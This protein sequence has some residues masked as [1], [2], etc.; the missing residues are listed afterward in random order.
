MAPIATPQALQGKFLN[1][2]YQ[3]RPVAD[4]IAVIYIDDYSLADETL[5]RW[6]DWSRTYYATAIENLNEAGAAVIGI[7][8]LFNRESKGLS[9]KDLLQTLTG[10]QTTGSIEVDPSQ[11]FMDLLPYL[12][13]SHPDDIILAEAIEEAGNVVLAKVPYIDPETGEFLGDGGSIDIIS[14]VSAGEGYTYGEMSQSDTILQL[15]AEESFD[16][17]ISEFFTGQ[18]V[19]IPT[20][21]RGNMYVNYSGATGSYKYFSFYDIY[22]NNF[23][24]EDVEGKILLIGVGSATLQDRYTTPLGDSTMPGVEIHANAIQTILENAFLEDA[25]FGQQAI[26]ITLT[27]VIAT[28]L[29]M[30]LPFWI[31]LISLLILGIIN[32]FA[33]KA[34]FNS[35]LILNIIYPYITLLVLYITSVIYRYLTE[36][37]EKSQVKSAFGHYVSK[38]V[39]NEVLKNPESLKLGGQKREITSFF[40]DIANFTTWSE[41]TEPNALVS[42]LNEYFDA[43]SKVIM[44]QKGTV[45]KFEGDALVAFFG[46]PLESPDHAILACQGALQAR[47]AIAELNTRWKEQG[48]KQLSFRIGINTGEATIGNIGSTERFDYTAIG[49][50]VNLAA[51]LEGTNKFYSTQIIISGNTHAKLEDKFELRRLDKVQVK[52]KDESINIYELLAEKDTLPKEALEII[53]TFHQAIEYYRNRDWAGAKQRFEEVLKKAPGDG[54]SQ[55][56]IKR[57]EEFIKNP[58]ADTWDGVWKFSEK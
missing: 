32:W 12:E 54:P 29:F 6:Q 20:D 31:A 33:I 28:A 9:E 1:Y 42:Q 51:R 38:E 41:G 35:G 17:V 56:Y 36:L 55:M 39:A 21:E 8:L 40:A 16:T 43:F 45:D 14:E 15:N 23:A 13:E 24:K 47:K 10:G 4:E 37:R 52:G 46:A 7:D 48:K 2:L 34:A 11:V 57:I 19:D 27:A 44:S 5:G 53:N 58:P 25:T 3:E 50:T 18:E 26:S 49:D 30:Y 22:S